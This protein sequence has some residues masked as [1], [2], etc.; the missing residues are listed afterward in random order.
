MSA[1][2]VMSPPV[3]RGSRS[4]VPD[5]L[6]RHG[7]ASGTPTPATTRVNSRDREGDLRPGGPT[8]AVEWEDIVSD[9]NHE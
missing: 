4:T 2:R 9:L 3:Y 8:Q 7:S 1:R 6:G 5:P